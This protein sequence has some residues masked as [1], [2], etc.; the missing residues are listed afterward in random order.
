[1][2]VK[3][4]IK[5]AC[6]LIG[7]SDVLNYLNDE[8]EDATLS[9]DASEKL[10]ELLLAVNLTNNT[11]AS[12]YFEISASTKCDNPSGVVSFESITTKNIVDI[13]KVTDQENNDIDYKVLSDGIHS[14]YKSLIVYYTYIPDDL[15]ISDSVDYYL[16]LSEI[17]FAYGVVSEYLFLVGDLEEASIWDEKFKN[18][19]FA[20]SR[21]RRNIVMPSKGW[22]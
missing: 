9:T 8:S 21:P 6:K 10:N 20:I 13:K 19:L 17:T 2:L 22:Y 4:I 14:D 7:I 16:K 12:Q 11:I 5:K 15:T 3:D 1:M 18:I